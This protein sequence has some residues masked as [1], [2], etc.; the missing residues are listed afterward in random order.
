MGGAQVVT[1][2]MAFIRSKMIAMLVGPGGIG[3]MGVLSS[4]NSNISTLAGWGLGTSA[5]RTI[6]SAPEEE[7]SRKISAARRFGSRL[8]WLGFFSVLILVVPVGYL[9]F[10]GQ[11]YALELLIA[12]LAVPCVVMTGMWTALLQAGGHVGSM[13]KTQTVSSLIG[14]LIGLPFIYVLGTLGIAVSIFLASLA[15]S[16]VTYQA[17]LRFAPSTRDEPS[18]LDIRELADLGLALQIG[19]ALGA[20]SSYIIRVMI[21]RS[22]GDDL[23]AGLADAGFYQ[24]A[25]AITGSLP[26]VIFSANNSDFY[27]RVASAKNEHQARRITETQIQ[28]SLLL[29]TPIL[30]GL[31]A[32]GPW[33]VRFLYA[34][35]FE[36]AAAL[37]HWFVWAN[38]FFLL[39]WPLGFWLTARGS[40]RTVA[41]FQ[42]LTYFLMVALGFVLIPI[43]GVKGAAASYLGCG[44]IYAVTLLI[45]T[46]SL[47]GGWV[48]LR[49]FGYFSAAAMALSIA[50]YA[51]LPSGK[52][53][54]AVLATCLTALVSVIIYL[55]IVRRAETEDSDA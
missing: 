36:P 27:P 3:L 10:Q 19:A 39:G 4:F 30:V 52:F 20:V 15:A 28:A 44:I 35:G 45:F 48:G 29:A 26:G 5:V 40:K 13:A 51:I 53:G 9:T 31:L 17:T 47:S 1:L 7:K 49:T 41:V 21:L 11:A 24:A 12:G 23:P 42:A 38:F 22:H 25:F 32:M 8:A 43:F 14:L 46:R 2:A 33:V 55:K 54:L 6:A 34:S 50:Q 18:K 37:L 16:I